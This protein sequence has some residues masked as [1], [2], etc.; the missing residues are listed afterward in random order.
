MLL[1]SR[2]TVVTRASVRPFIKNVFSELIKQINAKF[3]GKVP[4]HHIS[5]PFLCLFFKNL[6]FLIFYDFFSFSFIWDHMGEQNS[7]DILSESA[8]LGR[9]SA[10]VV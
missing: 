9:V 1:H 8:H 7:S 3:G 6:V 10:N 2:A 4:F 5:R